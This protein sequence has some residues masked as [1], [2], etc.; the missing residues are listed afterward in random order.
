MPFGTETDSVFGIGVCPRSSGNRETD[1]DFADELFRIAR[2]QPNPLK[3]LNADYGR[4]L[5][6]AKRP[7]EA[8]PVLEQAVKDTPDFGDAWTNL[9]WARLQ[10]GDAAAACA[11]ADEAVKQRPSDNAKADLSA[12]RS[13]AQCK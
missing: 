12:L 8:Q 3:S 1:A 10:N 7:R 2:R 4:G 5:L 9:A 13:S 6:I 11:A